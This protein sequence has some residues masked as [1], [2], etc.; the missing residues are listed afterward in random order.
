MSNTNIFQERKF[1]LLIL[2]R[3][4]GV[5][6]L[7]FC[8]HIELELNTWFNLFNT[9]LFDHCEMS[10][11]QGRGSSPYRGVNSQG[12]EYTQYGNG[13]YRYKN[14]NVEGNPHGSYYIGTTMRLLCNATE[15]RPA[16]RWHQNSNQGFREYLGG[17]ECW[18]DYEI[19]Q[20]S[21]CLLILYSIFTS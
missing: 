18:R 20:S 14:Y 8:R 2:N 3:E 19:S 11:K 4:V 15:D 16:Y 6:G 9:F 17:R 7:E 21:V 12:N 10:D 13:R 5:N 1:S